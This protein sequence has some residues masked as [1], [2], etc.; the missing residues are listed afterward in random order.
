M[1]RTSLA[2]KSKS[3]PPLDTP[4]PR[5]VGEVVMKPLTTVRPNDWNPNEMTAFEHEAL[6]AGLESDGWLKSQSLLVWGTDERGKTRNVII[7]GEQRW[8]VAKGMGFPQAPMV[9]LHGLTEA[10]A[11]ALTVKLDSKRGKFNQDRLGALLRAIQHD[12][13]VPNL[14]LD[15]GIPEEPLMKLLAEPEIPTGDEG[16][17]TRTGGG[18]DMPAGKTAHVRM[19]QLFFDVPQHDEFME[20][21]KVLRDRYRTESVTD[22]V[23]E[24]IRRASAAP[25]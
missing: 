13:D 1:A 5:V 12:L 2:K 17:P 21:V 25:K 8:T 4:K 20:Q 3:P 18:G 23:R 22:T 24:A 6:R 10:H 9:F 7:D 14:A 15:L 19:V 16:N 11:K